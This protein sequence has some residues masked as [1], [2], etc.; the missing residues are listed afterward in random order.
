MAE[1]KPGQVWKHNGTGTKVRVIRVVGRFVSVE[2]VATGKAR[3]R[4]LDKAWFGGTNSKS[5]T[6]Q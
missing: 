5:Y 4:P 2:D 6:K 1:V 3:Q